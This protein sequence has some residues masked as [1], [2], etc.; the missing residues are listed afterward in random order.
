MNVQA[1]KV[2]AY[3]LDSSCVRYPPGTIKKFLCLNIQQYDW[4]FEQCF[5][6]GQRKGF[7]TK[8][9][10]RALKAI[11]DVPSAVDHAFMDG[12]FIGAVPMPTWM[13]RTA[14]YDYT[15]TCVMLKKDF[16]QESSMSWWI[17]NYFM[18]SKFHCRPSSSKKSEL[19][20]YFRNCINNPPSKPLITRFLEL[21]N[22]Y[23]TEDFADRN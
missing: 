8:Q 9:V 20:S 4:T 17:D 7:S 16:K 18:D 21:F 19:I 22:T 12:M 5:K 2:S 1:K 10:I 11:V 23:N 13:Y 3:L 15:D 6:E 14:W